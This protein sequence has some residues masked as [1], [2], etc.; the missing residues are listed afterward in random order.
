AVESPANHP[1][2]ITVS[3][4][5]D[6]D[7]GAGGLSGFRCRDGET[8]D[9]L[10]TFSNFGQVVDIAAP[11]TCILSTYNDGGYD[12]KS[13]TSMA[14]P[15]V[16]GAAALYVA[17]NGRDAS[18]DGQIDKS[19]ADAVKAA[20]IAGALPQG[21]ACGIDPAS[22]P[23]GFAEPMLFLNGTA[24]DGTSECH[25]IAPDPSPPIAP[26]VSAQGDGYPIQLEW[27]TATDPESGILEYRLYRD[28]VPSSGLL[29]I[30]RPP[31]DSTSFTDRNTTPGATYSYEVEALNLQFGVSARSNRTEGTS[32]TD[33]P[34]DAGRWSLED[35]AGASA[36]DS[37]AWRRPGTLVNG[38]AWEPIGKIGGA[39][40]LDGADDRLD[41]DPAILDGAGDASFAV[42][43]KTT[44]T[45]TQTL[46][47]GANTTNDNEFSFQLVNDTLLR[48]YTGY[49]A[50]TGV[51]WD[52][53]SV[54]DGQWHHLVLLRNDTLN[55]VWAYRD[56][57]SLGG[58]GLSIPM[59]A[60]EV[61]ALVIGQDQD[62][63]LT[64][65]Q[66]AEAI[67]GGIDE[68]RVFTRLLTISEIEAIALR[69][70]TPPTG[71][72]QL[73]T[74][75]SGANI[76]LTWE[77]AVDAQS[78][79][80]S[81]EVWR[82]N[83]AGGPKQL[84]DAVPGAQTSFRDVTARPGVTYTYAVAAING[85]G[86]TG[87]PSPDASGVAGSAD[88][89][90]AGWWA[91]DDA[92]GMTAAD[93]SPAGAD[94]DLSGS[95]VWDQGRYGGALTFDDATDLVSLDHAALDGADD[96][97][98]SMW[99][100]TTFTSGVEAVIS[101]A[102]TGNDAEY[103]WF[104][105]YNP[106]LRLRLYT[107]ATS[108]T[109]VWWPLPTA[110][111][112]EWH[113]IAAVRH[114]SGD[115]ARL[116]FDGVDQGLRSAVFEPLEI[117]LGGLILGQDQD[118]V[119]GGFDP[120]QAF[121]GSLDDARFYRRLLT[122]AEVRDLAG[123][124]VAGIDT[125]P[126]TPP[127]G[128]TAVAA[129]SQITLDWNNNPEPDLAGYTIHRSTSNGGPY[130]QLATGLTT[131]TY[132]D[133]D[134]TNATT[135]Y[136][137]A[138]ATDTNN[139]TSTYS[140]Q[141]SATP[142]ATVEVVAMSEATAVGTISA[143]DLTATFTDDGVAEALTE[144]HGGGKPSGRVSDLDHRWTFEIGSPVTATLLIDAHWPSN[145][146]GDDF[147]FEYSIGGSDFV[148]LLGVTSSDVGVQEFGLPEDA[149]GTIVVRVVDTDETPG[150]A[151][152]DTVFVDM[153]V[154]RTSSGAPSTTTVR[155]V[156]TDAA[157][158]EFQL[159][160]GEF[161]LTR[162][163]STG[164]LTVDIEVTGNATPDSDYLALPTQAT[165]AD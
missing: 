15:Q 39:I 76:D 159:D 86:I 57:V 132:L 2:V 119:G 88:P 47:S 54:A 95:P 160:P 96:L 165:F 53:D 104:L 156:A 124:G 145:S 107:G 140:T 141:T 93:W 30:A 43:I 18:D 17:I 78:G 131:P 34:T 31:H 98:V 148:L 120:T 122:E 69:D 5:A 101:G 19:D 89:S 16:A 127:T 149:S 126:P 111:D 37:S 33:D 108:S 73:T 115:Q 49:S 9:T 137:V 163:T 133:T 62:G 112:G 35:G 123:M 161:T 158:S 118:V 97:T 21:D 99:V 150:N 65:F 138:T 82:D 136:Y 59:E 55:Q 28:T 103:E 143:N 83:G 106:D 79:I 152:L 146:D 162:S 147:A 24:F 56:G 13:G 64:G 128:L 114:G 164:S 44:K 102:N 29:L 157:A 26:T 7:G 27:S 71:P 135:Y 110:A 94:G 90:L 63:V 42:W 142:H 151:S 12:V 14:S 8:D 134:V 38:P 32:S 68:V 121:A 144:H 100:K 105:V 130:T 50:N 52:M 155:V 46:V 40:T 113:H 23:D 80:D 6:A 11:G 139:N 125:T 72:D 36:S 20:L 48:F 10:A 41:L 77:P 85:G 45:G 84:L 74:H 58:W 1:D 25:Q 60:L 91:F 116:Y 92:A 81:Y 61:D 109:Y 51:Q 154:L 3:A 22:D 67:A 87:S 70:L 75:T 66:S 117:E 153:L 4:V 129:D